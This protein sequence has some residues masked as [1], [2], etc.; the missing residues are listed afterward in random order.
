MPRHAATRRQHLHRQRPG[1]AGTIL[2]LVMLAFMV[3]L[4][5]S[6]QLRFTSSVE[7]EHAHIALLGARMDLLAQ[8][9]ARQAESVLLMD[10]EDAAA[11]EEHE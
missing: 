7:R 4:V 2:V 10:V 9:A 5:V 11:D 1:E 6:V 3:L 8:A